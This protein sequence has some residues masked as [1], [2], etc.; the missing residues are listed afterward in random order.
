M[1]K[2]GDDLVPHPHITDE[3]AGVTVIDPEGVGEGSGN[4]FPHPLGSEQAL[5]AVEAKDY[6]DADLFL[7]KWLVP[8]HPHLVANR[9]DFS[10]VGKLWSKELTKLSI[11]IAL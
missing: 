1:A 4:P 7:L 6:G 11:K 10:E 5:G 3:L 8:C 9:F 2:G